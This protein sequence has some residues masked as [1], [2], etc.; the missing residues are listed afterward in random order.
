MVFSQCKIYYSVKFNIMVLNQKHSER[1]HLRLNVVQVKIHFIQS[2]ANVIQ[3]HKTFKY[4]CYNIENVINS[5]TIFSDKELYNVKKLNLV[6]LKSNEIQSRQR[7]Q[8]CLP[9][10]RRIIDVDNLNA[11][12]SSTLSNKTGN[13]H[14]HFGNLLP[15]TPWRKQ[16]PFKSTGTGSPPPNLNRNARTSLS[17]SI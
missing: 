10:C 3:L 11:T 12:D 15:D 9:P 6:Q 13:S 1:S 8:R 4:K 7:T 5:T 16:Q 14:P 17:I 2:E